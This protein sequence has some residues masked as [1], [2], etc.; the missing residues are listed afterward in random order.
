MTDQSAIEE[1][2]EQARAALAENKYDA[3]CDAFRAHEAPAWGADAVGRD[4]AI[5]WH[6]RGFN[7]GVEF[8]RRDE[9]VSNRDVFEPRPVTDE[10]VLAALNASYQQSIPAPDLAYFG[11]EN[12]SKMR[13]ALEAAEGAR[14]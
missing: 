8:A 10:M 6:L 4:A 11:K 13:A 12:V 5:R 14:R 2:R 3:M 9:P 7:D 1:A